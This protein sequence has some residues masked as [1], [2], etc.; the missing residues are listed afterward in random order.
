[1]LPNVIILYTVLTFGTT[2]LVGGLNHGI[3]LNHFGEY[4]P[5]RFLDGAHGFL[6]FAT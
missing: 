6:D 1:M 2:Y 5:K 3:K 4:W